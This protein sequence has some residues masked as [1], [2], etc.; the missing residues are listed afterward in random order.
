MKQRNACGPA[1]AMVL[2]LVVLASPGVLARQEQPGTR[3]TQQIDRIMATRTY[4]VPR[5]G[6]ARWVPGRAAYTIVEPSASPD[7]GMDIVRYDAATGAREVLV[8]ARLL[9]PAGA[10]KG[11]AVDDYDWSP[12]GRRLLIFTNTRKV[13]RDNTRGDYWVVDLAPAGQQAL[14]RVLM[15]RVST[16]LVA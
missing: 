1:S 11:L 6:P 4:A 12:D 10:S 3:L 5:F 16:S 7:A 8:P 13:W 15:P 9:T 14:P 2:A